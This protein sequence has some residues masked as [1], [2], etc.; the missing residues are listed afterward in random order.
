MQWPCHKVNEW[1]NV[2]FVSLDIQVT[3]TIFTECSL[4]SNVIQFSRYFSPKVASHIYSQRDHTEQW[5]NL[6]SAFRKLTQKKLYVWSLSIHKQEELKRFMYNGGEGKWVPIQEIV[7]M[8]TGRPGPKKSNSD[9]L[10]DVRDMEAMTSDNNAKTGNLRNSERWHWWH[11]Y[12]QHTTL[13]EVE[14]LNSRAFHKWERTTF[15]YCQM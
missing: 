15:L 11:W 5:I 2:L 13:W 7:E 4:H 14:F 12:L 1:S 9:P 6:M 10:N 8:R 3:V